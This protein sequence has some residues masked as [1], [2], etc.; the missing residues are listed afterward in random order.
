[1]KLLSRV[2]QHKKGNV[3]KVVIKSITVTVRNVS[4]YLSCSCDNLTHIPSKCVWMFYQNSWDGWWHFSL[5]SP[6]LLLHA[7]SSPGT[8]V[9]FSFLGLSVEWGYCSVLPSIDKWEAVKSR[10]CLCRFPSGE[11]EDEQPVRIFYCSIV[12]ISFISHRTHLYNLRQCLV[13][14]LIWEHLFWLKPFQPQLANCHFSF[15]K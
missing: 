3:L 5:N 1:M 2:R 14:S 9:E 8:E 10:F 13:F 7:Y 15:R 4:H 11:A 12:N 6:V